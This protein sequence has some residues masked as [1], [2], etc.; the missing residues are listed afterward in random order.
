MIP[1]IVSILLI[2]LTAGLAAASASAADALTITVVSTDPARITGGDALVDITT[3]SQDALSVS[4]DGRDVSNA[5]KPANRSGHML[6]MISGLK[7]GKSTLSAKQGAVSASLTLTNHPITGPVFAG[8]KETPF[9]CETHKFK[10]PDGSMLPATRDADCSVD[11]VITYVYKPT[12]SA[13]L[14]P[15]PAGDKLPADVATTTISTGAKVP[16]VIR[17]ETGTINRGIYQTAVLHDPTKEPAPSP[18]ATPKG[19]NKRMLYV[20]AG[21]CGGMYRQGTT[22]GVGNTG[23]MLS[24]LF[25]GRGYMTIANSLNVFAMNCDDLLA[26]ETMMMTRERAIETLGAPFYTLGWGCSGGSHQVLQISDN[27][28]GLMDGIIPS[29]NSVDWGRFQQLNSDLTLL[30]DWFKTPSGQA[31]SDEQKVAITG[32][33]LN[34]SASKLGLSISGSCPEVVPADQVYNPKTNPKGVRCGIP[35]HQVNVLGR[36]PKTG[37]ARSIGDNTGVQYGLGALQAGKI[38]VAQF[39]TLNEQIGGYDVDGVRQPG[40]SVGDAQ[41]IEAAYKTGRIL[42]AGGGLKDVPIVELRNYTDQDKDA[43]HLKYGT[44][45]TLARLVRETGSRANYVVVLESHR[46]GFMSASKATDEMA[47]FAITK[48]DDWLTALM[49]DHGSGSRAEKIARAKP[50][51]LVDACYDPDGQRIVEEQTLTG[52]R[53]AA[54]Y[55]T[56]LPPRMVAG[57][58]LTNDVLKCQLKPVNA[59]DYGVKLTPGESSRLKGAFPNGVCDWSKPGVGQVPLA[60]TWQAF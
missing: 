23:N 13:E 60:G 8:P 54:L 36:D 52:G 5:F 39:I 57:G 56:S 32:A 55:P 44:Y 40:R 45:V 16:H 6:G 28:P 22:T 46:N 58:P 24:D 9:F 37:F 1:R 34:T 33:P 14:K 11:T 35:D 19:W 38:S 48:M 41:G 12:G 43:V 29:C 10:L 7:L 50:S 26:A 51:D 59:A 49:N 31:L 21:G 17:V 27:Y 47:H 15:L 30:Y 18:L 2:A 42:N 4:L 53:C 25:V 20:V 3:Q